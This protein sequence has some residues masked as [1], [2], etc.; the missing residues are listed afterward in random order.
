[1]SRVSILP[2]HEPF[3]FPRVSGDEPVYLG[4][5]GFSLMF[6]PRERG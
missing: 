1:M 2:S 4:T 6:S 3:G 5:A